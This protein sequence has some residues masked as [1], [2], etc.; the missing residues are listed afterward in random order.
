MKDSFK[1]RSRKKTKDSNSSVIIPLKQ[2]EC[3]DT[4]S[5]I[6]SDKKFTN[7]LAFSEMEGPQ[8]DIEETE[9][10]A[11]KS[12]HNDS[13]INEDTIPGVNKKESEESFK[14]L[15]ILF[16]FVQDASLFEVKIVSKEK[17]RPSETFLLRMFQVWTMI[18]KL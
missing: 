5:E 9:K 11:Q 4:K 3:G 10:K 16:Y 2:A 1:K 17:E 7:S 12:E 14:F 8:N 18:L 13:K 15:I 6:K